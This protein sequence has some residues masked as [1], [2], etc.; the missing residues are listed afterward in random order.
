MS[1]YSIQ[2][3]L[4][5]FCIVFF[6]FQVISNNSF[7]DEIFNIKA[8]KVRFIEQ[9]NSII[10]SGNA[11]A[12]NNNKKIYADKITYKK[13]EGIL[14]ANGNVKLVDN[15]NTITAEYVKYNINTKEVDAKKM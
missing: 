13:K 2:K 5:I 4:F 1:D 14:L 8:E 9:K 15:K 6:N 3:K 7:S 11:E 10:A 12:S